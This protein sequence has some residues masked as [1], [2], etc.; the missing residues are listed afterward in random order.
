MNPLE[1]NT[2]KMRVLKS[3]LVGNVGFILANVFGK[4]NQKGE[5]LNVIFIYKISKYDGSYQFKDW[6]ET[7]APYTYGCP[8]RI[9]DGST[10]D[11]EAAVNWRKINYDLLSKKET[12]KNRKETMKEG[13]LYKVGNRKVEF[14]YHYKTTRFVGR[15]LGSTKQ[16][17]FEYSKID[18]EESDVLAPISEKLIE[19]MKEKQRSEYLSKWAVA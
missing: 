19:E 13:L 18:W 3:A 7:C 9:L 16:F 15:E 1:Q 6:D 12:I 17:S 10:C 14:L 8:K 5:D 2:E 4:K 11:D